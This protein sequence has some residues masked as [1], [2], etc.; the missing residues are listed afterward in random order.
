M[1]L[2]SASNRASE[3][4]GPAIWRPTGK[5][6]RVRPQVTLIAGMCTRFTGHVKPIRLR[7][8]SPSVSPSG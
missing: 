1:T 6:A 3:N 8:A 5:P 7:L 4:F 2:A